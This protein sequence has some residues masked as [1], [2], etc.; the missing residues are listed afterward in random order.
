MKKEKRTGNYREDEIVTGFSAAQRANSTNPIFSDFGHTTGFS[1]NTSPGRGYSLNKVVLFLEKLDSKSLISIINEEQDIGIISF[2]LDNILWRDKKLAEE[3]VK[4]INIDELMRKILLEE[5]LEKIYFLVSRIS[6]LSREINLR[7]SEKIDLVSLARKID[8]EQNLD[9]ICQTLFEFHVCNEEMAKRLLKEI[10]FKT[11]LWKVIV[12]RDFEK[13]AMLIYYIYL[14]YGNFS[15][16]L[17]VIVGTK[18]EK[19]ENLE[20]V[21]EFLFKLRLFKSRFE[22]K[23][24]LLELKRKEQDS[25]NFE[26]G[27]KNAKNSLSGKIDTDIIR[28]VVEKIDL[29]NLAMKI[30]LEKRFD[31]IFE[32]VSELSKCNK[33]IIIE[34]LSKINIEYLVLKYEEVD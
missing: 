30:D 33:E 26:E 25:E 1:K 31:R 9:T 7:F 5:S 6:W 14:V 23:L 8:K 3:I 17:A 20:K 2:I 15:E 16:N 24:H 12:E 22:G 19:E 29:E 28:H 11:L 34:L 32:L 4:Q 10:N 18:F 27:L 13:V 21:M